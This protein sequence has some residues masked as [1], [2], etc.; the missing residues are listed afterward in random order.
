MGLARRWAAVTARPARGLERG[1]RELRHQMIGRSSDDL[2]LAAAAADHDRAR[3]PRGGARRRRCGP[4]PPRRRACAAAAGTPSPRAAS[5]RRAADMLENMRVLDLLGRRRAARCAR[6]FWSTSRSTIWIERSSSLTMSS[7][8]NSSWRISSASSPSTLGDRRRARC[9]R[10]SGGVVEDLGERLDAAGGGEYSCVDDRRTA[11]AASRSRC[12]CD[13]LGLR[14]AHRRDPQGDVGL[15]SSG[16]Q[17]RAPAAASVVCR[18]AT[19]SA[20]VCGDSLRRNTAICS[21]GVRRRN[22]NGRRSNVRGQAADDLLGARGGPS[23]RSST[24]RG[25][26]DAALGERSPRRSDGLGSASMTTLGCVVRRG[27]ACAPPSRSESA[28]TSS[29]PRCLKTSAAARSG[30]SAIEQ[31]PRPSAPAADRASVRAASTRITGRPRPSRPAPAAATRSGSRSMS[32]SSCWRRRRR[33]RGRHE[34]RA[35]GVPSASSCGERRRRLD[36]AQPRRARG[37]RLALAAAQVA[38]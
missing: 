10:S 20:I 31:R 15:R 33:A 4:A 24:S 5:R 25:V 12:R 37:E 2:V 16:E 23:E 26:V 29:S 11:S 3:R 6:S 14:L 17:R 19:T 13:D 21:A 32:S 30:P 28:S 35:A 22:S 1:E 9:A 7:K 8:V 34:R 18:L 27:P 38:R 36:L